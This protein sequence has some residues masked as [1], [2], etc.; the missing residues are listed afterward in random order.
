MVDESWFTPNEIRFTNAQTRFLIKYLHVIQNGDWVDPKGQV[1]ERGRYLGIIE[2]SHYELLRD[3]SVANIKGGNMV[4]SPPASDMALLKNYYKG[5]VLEI[6]NE[7][8]TRLNRC[9][10]KDLL[11][12]RYANDTRIEQLCGI[13][14]VK[15]NHIYYRCQRAIKF[16]SGRK[17]RKMDYKAWIKGG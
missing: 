4:S 15:R 16:L 12:A 13:F 14:K 9:S 1:S 8:E 11:I 3:T 5:K 10:D 7:L 2:N 17:M 6:Y